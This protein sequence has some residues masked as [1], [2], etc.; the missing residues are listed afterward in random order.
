[1]E[2]HSSLK[3]SQQ[4]KRDYLPEKKASQQNKRD[5]LPEKKAI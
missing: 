5:Y 3:L 1:V 2:V 4:N